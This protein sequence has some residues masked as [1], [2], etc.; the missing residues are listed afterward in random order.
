MLGAGKPV[1]YGFLLRNST[2]LNAGLPRHR[3]GGQDRD[4]VLGG[5]RRDQPQRVVEE[6]LQPAGR[7]QG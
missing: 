3:A 1:V 5:G 4:V 6:I 2:P 7:G